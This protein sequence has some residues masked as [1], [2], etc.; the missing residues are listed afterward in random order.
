VPDEIRAIDSYYAAMPGKPGTATR[1][2]ST[3]QQVEINLL[4]IFA[5]RCTSEKPCPEPASSSLS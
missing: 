2:F 4:G 1:I 5:F 3:L